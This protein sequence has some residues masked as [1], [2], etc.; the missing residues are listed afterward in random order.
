M[1]CGVRD[2]QPQAFEVR[3]ALSDLHRPHVALDRHRFLQTVVA[4]VGGLSL[5]TAFPGLPLVAAQ[6]P[7]PTRREYGRPNVIIVRFGGGVRRRETIDSEHTY[8][9]FLLHELAPRGCFFPH[10]EIASL[11]GMR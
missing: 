1:R 8:S 11:P 3:G 6:D 7:T 5:A 2:P 10:M 9:P 4:G